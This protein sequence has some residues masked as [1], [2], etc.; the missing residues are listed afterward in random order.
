[1][2]AVFLIVAVVQHMTTFAY[3]SMSVDLDGPA[4][5][6]WHVVPCLHAV[7]AKA[8]SAYCLRSK[9]GTAYVIASQLWSAGLSLGL[10]ALLCV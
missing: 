8:I 9:V 5:V 4:P 2:I 10:F 3:P 6:V 1:V 7:L